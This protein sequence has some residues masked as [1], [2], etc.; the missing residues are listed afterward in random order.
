MG[1]VEHEVALLRRDAETSRRELQVDVAV[2]RT[3]TDLA[4]FCDAEASRFHHHV[5]RDTRVVDVFDTTLG[6]VA[7]FADQRADR[8]GVGG[9]TK[10]NQRDDEASRR[11]KTLEEE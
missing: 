3:I 5:E 1:F 8:L 4:L 7:E 9:T 6:G 10:H 11:A 2:Q